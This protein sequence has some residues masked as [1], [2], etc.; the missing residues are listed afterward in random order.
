MTVI[1]APDSTIRH[2]VD[3]ER[4]NEQGADLGSRTPPRLPVGLSR[5][6]PV[7]DGTLDLEG[8]TR[9][10]FH[11]VCPPDVS[12]FEDA[13]SIS[14][15]IDSGLRA[16]D[17]P[18]LKTASTVAFALK[19]LQ[20]LGATTFSRHAYRAEEA[21]PGYWFHAEINCSAPSSDHRPEQAHVL[22]RT[23]HE[24]PRVAPAWL[25]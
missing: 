10:H 14:L 1:L 8:S 15:I 6:H 13:A 9:L 16:V 23:V 25:R 19:Y 3:L 20:A 24:G 17:G 4:R 22:A 12:T 21:T 2:I 11:S 5:C 18:P 7:D